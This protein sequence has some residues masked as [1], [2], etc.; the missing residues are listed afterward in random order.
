L[1]LSAS[2]AAGGM[3]VAYWCRHALVLFFPEM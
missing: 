1:L 3:L 2:G